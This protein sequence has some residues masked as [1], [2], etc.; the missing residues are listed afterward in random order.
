MSSVPDNLL[1]TAAHDWIRVD[2]DTAVVGITDYAQE[3]LGDV[4]YVELPEVDDDLDSGD[5]CVVVESLKAASE[6]VMPIAGKILE[7]NSE[8]EETPETVN[9]D[10][11]GKGWFFKFEI[12]DKGE[13]D[14]LLS[15]EKYR[16]LL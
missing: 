11:Y 8:L 6:I 1:Y 4:T 15:P 10:P 13:L 14:N 2:G 12:R 3:S 7:V 9:S 16:E 5:D